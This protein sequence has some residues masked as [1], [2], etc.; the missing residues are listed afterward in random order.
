[1]CIH[2]HIF[3]RVSMHICMYTFLCLSVCMYVCM[4]TPTS[5]CFSNT[6][7]IKKQNHIYTSS[8]SVTCTPLTLSLIHTYIHTYERL[9]N[10][11]VWATDWQHRTPL[12]VADFWNKSAVI[13][14]L[15]TAMDLKHDP[16]V[17]NCGPVCV[18]AYVFLY[19]YDAY[20][21]MHAYTSMDLRHDP[22]VSNCGPVC[23]CAYVFLYIYDVY[24]YMHAY[25]TTHDRVCIFFLWP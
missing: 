22:L 19:I 16:L 14:L 6:H 20:I 1:V 21:Y 25:T 10:I 13:S 4:Y 23:V 5:R 8:T 15:A 7:T 12:Q 9:K 17:S 2:V 24:I 18:C 11:T 3:V